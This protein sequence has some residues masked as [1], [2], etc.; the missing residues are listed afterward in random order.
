VTGNLKPAFAKAPAGKLETWTLEFATSAEATSGRLV[1]A[2]SG[3]LLAIA[4]VAASAV[5]AISLLANRP[6]PRLAH[7]AQ[8]T[9]ALMKGS[10]ISI[11]LS[12]VCQY[13]RGDMF[14][15]MSMP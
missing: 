2:K 11:G 5:I 6:S 9:K 8:S 4:H 1:N 12:T 7:T 13:C 15:V 10:A 3:A 14:S